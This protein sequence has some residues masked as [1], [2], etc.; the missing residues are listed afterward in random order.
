MR[1][2]LDENFPDPPGFDPSDLDALFDVTNLSD[3][4][5]GLV[6]NRTPDW[7]LYLVAHEAGYDAL[8]TR[9]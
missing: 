9:D 5:P 6:G 3:Q 7:F 1:V 4:D 8:V 2:L